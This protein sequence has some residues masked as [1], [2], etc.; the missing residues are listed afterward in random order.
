MAEKKDDG[1]PKPNFIRMGNNGTGG[2]GGFFDDLAKNPIDTAINAGLNYITAGL[3]GY[4]D[5]KIKAGVLTRAVDE[6]I[7]EVT[8]RNQG[9]KRNMEAADAV[10]ADGV[11][12]A[13]QLADEQKR[14][15][16]LDVEASVNAGLLTQSQSSQSRNQILSSAESSMTKDFLGL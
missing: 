5:G 11:A 10:A 4:E 12:R 15:Q 8:G 2:V 7:G 9:R 14:K 13:Q 1:P 6:G 3:V 16:R